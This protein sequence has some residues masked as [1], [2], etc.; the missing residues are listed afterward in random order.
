MFKICYFDNV[1]CK[2]NPAEIIYP[3]VRKLLNWVDNHEALLV[4]KTKY[5]PAMRK[6]KH[7]SVW[8]LWRKIHARKPI[9]KDYPKDIIEQLGRLESEGKLEWVRIYDDITPALTADAIVVLPEGE[10]IH[11][12]HR[13]M[14]RNKEILFFTHPANGVT[15][16]SSDDKLDGLLDKSLEEKNVH[17]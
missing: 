12:I 4:I 14:G 1:T 8:M 11:K 16:F 3:F 13:V 10:V 9:Y 17:P 15:A 6:L 5:R 7:G 2:E